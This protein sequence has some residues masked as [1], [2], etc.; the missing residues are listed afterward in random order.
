MAGEVLFVAGEA[1]G[2]LHAAMLASELQA[3]RPELIL[4]GVGGHRMEAATFEREVM[5]TPS[6]LNVMI[7]RYAHA[8]LVMTSQTAAC[9][10]LHTV[11]MRMCRW[12]KMTHNRIQRSEFPMRQEFLAQ[13]LGVHRPSVSIAASTLQRAGLISYSRGRMQLLDLE[14]LAEGSCECAE[15][16]EP[17][18][19]HIFGQSWRELAK[20]QHAGDDD[21]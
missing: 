2:D 6:P 18:F 20:A 15:L 1:S 10:R 12:L 19:D 8:F 16:V 11:D 14:G 13:M 5:R 7:A 3:I 9:N 17:Q 21:F 4:T